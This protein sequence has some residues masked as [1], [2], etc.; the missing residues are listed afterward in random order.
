M[1]LLEIIDKHI[2]GLRHALGIIDKYRAEVEPQESEGNIA[3][4]VD[5]RVIP[6]INENYESCG[7]CIHFE[8][9]LHIC[10]ARR[11]VHAVGFLSECYVPK[12]KA[13][14]EVNNE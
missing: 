5:I 13:E 4:K 2:D 8:D 9:E 10:V 11:C 14:S 6:S 3:D 12:N 1:I 7:D